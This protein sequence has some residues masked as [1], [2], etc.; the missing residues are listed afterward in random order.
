METDLNTHRAEWNAGCVYALDVSQGKSSGSVN[1]E[2]LITL[3]RIHPKRSKIM[4]IEE[5]RGEQPGPNA[6]KA[7]TSENVS[8]DMQPLQLANVSAGLTFVSFGYRFEAANYTL[9]AL[10]AAG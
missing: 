10:R 8:A 5:P 3:L 2:G 6:V 4:R 1:R 9:P 7:E